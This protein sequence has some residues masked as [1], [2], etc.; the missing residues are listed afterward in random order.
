[1]QLVFS[2]SAQMC[3]NDEST[4]FYVT[5][6]EISEVLHYAVVWS[7]FK[8]ATVLLHV[9]QHATTPLCPTIS[10]K[11]PKIFTECINYSSWENRRDNRLLYY[12]LHEWQFINGWGLHGD[13]GHAASSSNGLL[14]TSGP[15]ATRHHRL[16]T[17]QM[18]SKKAWNGNGNAL[19]GTHILM[20]MT[21]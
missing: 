10:W 1:M 14:F 19:W 3:D 5:G 6:D 21:D 11:D 17:E 7:R 13:T 9:P 18:T 20:T 16:A 15:S 12:A 4:G 2:K 8:I